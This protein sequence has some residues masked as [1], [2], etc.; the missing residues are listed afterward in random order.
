[1][2]WS[3]NDQVAEREVKRMKLEEEREARAQRAL[4]QS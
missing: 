1:M 2:H 3:V 4:I